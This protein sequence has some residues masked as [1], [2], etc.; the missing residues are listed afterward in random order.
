MARGSNPY[1]RAQGGARTW[2]PTFDGARR[3]AGVSLPDGVAG[4]ADRL[5]RL[6]S[7]WLLAELAPGRLSPWVPVA[8]GIGVAS[9]F[10]VDREPSVWA[11]LPLATAAAVVAVLTRRRPFGFPIAVALAGALAGLAIATLQATRIS[12]PILK[13]PIASAALSGFVEIREERERS[14]RIVIRIERFDAPGITSAPQ[15]V[16]VA[17]RKGSAPPVGSFIELKARLSPPM[18]PLRPGGYD[19]ARDMYFQKIGASGYALGAV[20]IKAPPVPPGVWLRYATVIDAIRESIDDHIRA[21]LPGDRG[22]IASALITGKRDAISTPVNDAMYVSSLAHVLSISGYHMA[23]VSGIVFFMVRALLAL[24]PW[25]AHRRPIKK[26]AASAALLAATF[27]LLLSGAE[28]ATQRSYIMIA[29]VLIGVM[30]DRPTLTFR[31]LAVA[32][33]VVLLLAP[34]A[35]VHPGFQMSFAATLALIAAY[36]HGF[37]WRANHDSPLGAL[38]ALWGIREVASLILASLVAGLATTL[39]AAYHFHRL[40]PYGVLANLLA[41]PIVSAVIMPMGILGVVSMPFGFDA[42][43]WQLMRQGI[44]WMNAVALWV[45]SLPGA[46]GRMPAF[47]IGPLLL[48]TVGLLFICLLRTP[49]R[50]SGTFVA[51]C[52]IVWALA[53]PQPDILVAGDGQTAAFRGANG[54]LVVLRAGRDTFAIKEWLAADADA[55][56]SKDG[57]LGKGVTC[58]AVG[59]IGRLG[60]GRLISMVLGIEA[61]AEDCARAAVVISERESP[62]GCGATVIDRAIWQSYGAV[63][64]RW[65][66]NQFTRTAALPGNQARPWTHRK[67]AISENADLA[68]RRSP[69]GAEPHQEDL[70]P[71]D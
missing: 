42:P 41:M 53:T 31:T 18:Q 60:D 32:T 2:A 63:A 36:Q 68:R 46:I 47:G 54:Q 27:Y 65:T 11:G 12:H 8:F 61:F 52:A 7:Q 59:C 34:Q 48:G 24:I 51:A 5:R 39:Y 9:Y 56:V 19:F 64:L 28:V 21:A 10:A 15:R 37:R 43:F 38:A 45:A 55:R 23:V 20:K 3:P 13:A 66:G 26:W 58:D 44:D 49:L 62:S 57:G 33:I 40:A 30:L 16:R 67:R 14:D 1:G 69:G 29:I 6:L 71:D 70:T 50:W 4:A 25:L 17:V 35:I 22:S